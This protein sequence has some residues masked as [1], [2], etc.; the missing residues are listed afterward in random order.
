MNSILKIL[1]LSLV[2]VFSSC[3]NDSITDCPPLK[4]KV[5][6]KD[7]N[8]FNIDFIDLISP[9][10]EDLPFGEY[11]PTLSYAL[12]DRVSGKVVDS[13]TIKTSNLVDNHF[14]L[15]FDSRIGYG[16]Y[17]LSLWGGHEDD[18]RL[19]TGFKHMALHTVI[20]SGSDIYLSTKEIDYTPATDQ[21][22]MEMQRIKGKLLVYVENLPS[23]YKYIRSK[24]SGVYG[25]VTTLLEYSEEA[26][27]ESIHPINPEFSCL[28]KV[29]VAPS[30][31]IDQSKLSL[32][33]LEDN[34]VLRNENPLSENILDGLPLAIKRNEITAIKIVYKGEPDGNHRLLAL[35][36]NSWE[37]IHNSEID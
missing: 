24:I 16:S 5:V 7:K 4:I 36:D 15:Q 14:D 32:D 8:Y 30:L 10:D 23:K 26:N 31:K 25:K 21:H 3:I 17:R 9:K 22:Q 13:A 28:A 1:A 34:S 6:V 37:Q 20:G 2:I 35:I 19:S 33:L 12:I 18:N 11:I 27:V 29:H